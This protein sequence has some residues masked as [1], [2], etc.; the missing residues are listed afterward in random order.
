MLNREQTVDQLSAPLKYSTPFQENCYHFLAVFGEWC[1]FFC[2]N[3]FKFYIEKEK[4]LI[5]FSCYYLLLLGQF[6]TN[7]Q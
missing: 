4:R 5:N 3:L 1:C 2:G 7:M 6:N